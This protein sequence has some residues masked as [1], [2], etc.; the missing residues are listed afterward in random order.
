[1][2]GSFGR[3]PRAHGLVFAD[4]RAHGGSLVMLA[5]G[6]AAR[7]CASVQEACGFH[8]AQS[9]ARAQLA[10]EN[11]RSVA[12][13]I[14]KISYER[15]GALRWKV[16]R[17]HRDR[18]KGNDFFR[19]L[20]RIPNLLSWPSSG[21]ISPRLRSPSQLAPSKARAKIFLRAQPVADFDP[22]SMSAG[23][24][25][26]ISRGQRAI[27]VGGTDELKAAVRKVCAR[28]SARFSAEEVIVSTGGKQCC[29]MPYGSLSAGDQVFDNAPY[30]SVSYM[31]SWP[32]ASAGAPC[33]GPDFVWR[34][35]PSRAPYSQIRADHSNNLPIQ[36]GALWSKEQQQELALCWPSIRQVQVMSDEIYEKILSA[37]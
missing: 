18:H 27:Q 1:M 33:P 13:L 36:S 21:A 31:C 20:E 30:W 14:M 25:A 4:S 9:A 3:Q 35:R 37:P 17:I 12:C 19:S 15:C 6:N 22:R 29:T 24:A 11:I 23:R 26:A 8:L 2:S 16:S 28:Q 34:L 32:K 10:Q 5:K 7:P